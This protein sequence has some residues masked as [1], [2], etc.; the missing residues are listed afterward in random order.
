MKLFHSWRKLPILWL[1]LAC[2]IDRVNIIG[3]NTLYMISFLIPDGLKLWHT[4][5]CSDV[6]SG[7]GV[8]HWEDAGAQGSS[9]LI[10]EP[11]PW[12]E[13]SRC[14]L[15]PPLTALFSC[16]LIPHLLLISVLFL[17]QTNCEIKNKFMLKLLFLCPSDSTRFLINYV[18]KMMTPMFLTCFN[19]W[20]TTVKR[21]LNWLLFSLPTF[22]E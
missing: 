20:L 22:I 16:R 3:L 18:S 4:L 10:K 11:P 2:F 19:F 5:G 1:R 9:D 17:L 14:G 15:L 12:G 7:R 8:W 6:F 13:K 21:T